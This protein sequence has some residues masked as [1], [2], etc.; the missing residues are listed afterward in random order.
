ME[1]KSTDARQELIL[2]DRKFLNINGVINIVDF[3]DTQ[4]TLKTNLGTVV[5]EGRDMKIESLSKDEGRATVI[6]DFDGF[7]YKT[8]SDKKSL[9]SKIFG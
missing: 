4:L 8:L 2:N 3:T 6:G 1:A 9:I 5:I 7:Y